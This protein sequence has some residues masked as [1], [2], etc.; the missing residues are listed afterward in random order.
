MSL[1]DDLLELATKMAN[2]KKGD[3]RDARRRRAIS[4]AYYALFHFLLEQ[5]AV[6]LA[7]HTGGRRMIGR[8]YSHGDMVKAAKAFKS[9][10]GALPARLKAPFGLTFP[11]VPAELTRVATA[12][13]DLQ[14]GRHNADYDPTKEFAAA[15]TRLLVRQAG[16]AFADWNRISSMPE[17]RDICELFLACLLLF[18]RLTKY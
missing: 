18:E 3:V 12:F 1:S 4:T 11:T 2:Y 5:G 9:G 7:A 17:H 16:Q 14:E 10:P 8:V 15:E 6:K 13:V